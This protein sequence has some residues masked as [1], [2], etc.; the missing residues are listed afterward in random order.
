MLKYGLTPKSDDRAS[1]LAAILKLPRC[2]HDGRLGAVHGR[3][4]PSPVQAIHGLRDST[5]AVAV[6]LR[7]GRV[8][9][10]ARDAKPYDPAAFFS[11]LA[12][13]RRPT[14]EAPHVVEPEMKRLCAGAG[15]VVVLV[16]ELPQ[17][18]A[19]LHFPR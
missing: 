6:R 19:K 12:A 4:P 1:T 18:S 17:T 13:V 7:W 8:K 2:Q 14:P 9:A 11:A 15:V 5:G 16:P 10:A 3:W